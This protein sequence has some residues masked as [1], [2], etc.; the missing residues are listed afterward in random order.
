MGCCLAHVARLTSL[1]VSARKLLLRALLVLDSS[2]QS[3]LKM[4]FAL[5]AHRSWHKWMSHLPSKPTTHA[6]QADIDEWNELTFG[7]LDPTITNHYNSG[8]QKAAD[9]DNLRAAFQCLDHSLPV[10]MNTDATIRVVTAKLYPPPVA[11]NPYTK[12]LSPATASTL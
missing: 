4:F 1:C 10:A 11:G 5:L 2:S 8:A 6:L 9:R 12:S 7:L 3:G